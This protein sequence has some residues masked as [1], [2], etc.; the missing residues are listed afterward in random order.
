V[1][2]I[3]RVRHLERLDAPARLRLLESRSSGQEIGKP[4]PADVLRERR[5]RR[6][7]A[8]GLPYEDPSLYVNGRRPTCAEIL[9]GARARRCADSQSQPAQQ[10]D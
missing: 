5:R 2:L 9:R 7:E 8:S 1:R 10:G 3:H 6:L 4:S